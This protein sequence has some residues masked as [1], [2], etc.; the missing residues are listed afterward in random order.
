M[1]DFFLACART[2]EAL[3]HLLR[4]KGHFVL[5]YLDDFVGVASTEVQSYHAYDDLSGLSKHLGLKLSLKKCF[6]QQ[7]HLLCLDI[8]CLSHLCK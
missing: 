8:Q 3:V 5:C 2:T 7:K 1:L 6:P 4:E